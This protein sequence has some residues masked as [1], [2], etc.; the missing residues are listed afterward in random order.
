MTSVYCRWKPAKLC[1]EGVWP[2][3][4]ILRLMLQSC[5]VKHLHLFIFSRRQGSKRRP[6]EICVC[7]PTSTYSPNGLLTGNILVEQVKFNWGTG[8]I[9]PYGRD[10][11]SARWQGKLLSPSSETFTLYLRAD[12]AARLYIDH[13]LVI[14]AWEGAADCLYFAP[15]HAAYEFSVDFCR[16]LMR[17]FLVMCC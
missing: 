15:V 2:C 8:A 4:C 5:H 10:Y 12:D 11:V 6:Q 14:D 7:M 9:T 17:F 1:C 13:Q 3:R 16:L